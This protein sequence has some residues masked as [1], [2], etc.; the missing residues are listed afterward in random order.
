MQ[1][2]V[3]APV[4]FVMRHGQTV[5]EKSSY[6]LAFFFYLAMVSLII[7][8]RH[9]IHENYYMRVASPKYPMFNLRWA[10]LWSDLDRVNQ[11]P[12]FLVHFMVRRMLYGA[13][14]ILGPVFFNS[15][16]AV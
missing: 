1:I 2:S 9:I 3:F 6:F 13:I 8:G 14:L 16:S 11:K 10:E 7:Y 15:P 12:L 4:E 5:E